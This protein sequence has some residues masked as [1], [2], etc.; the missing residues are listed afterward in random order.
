MDLHRIALI[1]TTLGGVHL[2]LVGLLG[3]D[4]ITILVGGL[5]LVQVVHVLIGVSAVWVLVHHVTHHHT[6]ET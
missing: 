3:L 5:G 2:G 1:I 6:V 4:L